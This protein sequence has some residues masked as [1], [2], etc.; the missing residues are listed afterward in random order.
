MHLLTT[1]DTNLLTKTDS[2]DSLSKYHMVFKSYLQLS[3]LGEKKTIN[4]FLKYVGSLLRKFWKKKGRV[5][6]K[7]PS[8]SSEGREKRKRMMGGGEGKKPVY[9]VQG[10]VIENANSVPTVYN[11]E[12]Q[13][14]VIGLLEKQQSRNKNRSILPEH[15]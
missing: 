8:L 2:L 12:G 5:T 13:V 1:N 10:K 14:L 4:Y 3:F 15:V 9:L 7:L 6:Q 11:F